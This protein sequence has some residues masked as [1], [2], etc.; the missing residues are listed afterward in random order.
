MP[1]RKSTA[2]PAGSVGELWAGG[3][4]LD[5]LA[6]LVVSRA[7]GVGGVE[8]DVGVEG[9][10]HSAIARRTASASSRSTLADIRPVCHSN[11]WAGG[12]AS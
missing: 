12:T 1:I 6:R 11:G 10:A 7:L 5:H 3:N 8:E 4:P 2:A 9:E